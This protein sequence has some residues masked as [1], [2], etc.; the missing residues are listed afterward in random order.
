MPQIEIE[1]E[2]DSHSFSPQEYAD[3]DETLGSSARANKLLR[4]QHLVE[5]EELPEEVQHNPDVAERALE[6]GAFYARIS[7]PFWFKKDDDEVYDTFGD[8]DAIY[9]MVEDYS[10]GAWRIIASETSSM[11]DQWFNWEWTFVPKSLTTVTRA[12]VSGEE[13]YDDLRVP[14]QQPA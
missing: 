7:V 6:E 5:S 8:D 14:V 2:G 1:A 11:G 12:T 13:S 9:A 3:S 4:T 10:D